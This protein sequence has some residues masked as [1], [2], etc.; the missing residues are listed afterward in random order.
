MII[1]VY[2]EDG[3]RAKRKV[4][5][6]V[7][8]FKE[9]HD[10]SG[11]NVAKFVFEDNVAEIK[12]EL[13]ALPFLAKRRLIIVRGLASAITRKD[14]AEEWTKALAVRGEEIIA[15]LF[16]DISAEKSA[17]NK[18]YIALR[19]AEKMYEYVYGVMTEKEATAWIMGEAKLTGVEWDIAA[20]KLLYDK[21]G[22]DP[23]RFAAEFQKLS[24]GAN[25]V[26]M[27]EEVESFVSELIED[28]VFAFLDA[29]RAKQAARA[30]KLLQNEMN[31]GTEPGLLLNLL[32]KDVRIMSEL[33]AMK[34]VDGPN[35]EKTAAAVL[36]VPP[37]VV[38]KILPRVSRM[39]AQEMTPMMQAV[40]DAD[41][42]VKTSAK[43]DRAALE[44]L[45]IKLLV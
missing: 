34:K 37:F 15:V 20:A 16:D 28:A 31:R 14:E 24:A 29:V 21:V 22:S 36:G 5:E 18:L 32:A 7:L 44:E 13:G 39:T 12:S 42:A 6:L 2:G 25:G 8:K 30:T 9:K 45:T 41:R 19:G 23:W 11:I 17:T 35:V 43:T 40:V 10:P 1:L 26:V 27:V 3:F 38:K 33:W 4:E